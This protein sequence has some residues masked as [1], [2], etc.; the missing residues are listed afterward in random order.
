MASGI[1]GNVYRILRERL[2]GAREA[3]GLTQVD[4]ALKLGKSQ[5]FVSKY[6]QGE[7]RLDI[8]DF[9][10]ICTKLGVT[11]SE[12]LAGIGGPKS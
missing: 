1:H 7:R 3:A 6:E 9:V 2:V 10:S 11:P 12:I 8:A 4:L 5:S